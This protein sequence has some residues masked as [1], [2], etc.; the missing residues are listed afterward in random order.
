MLILRRSF[1]AAVRVKRSEF[2][3]ELAMLE[4]QKQN[5]PLREIEKRKLKV[6]REKRLIE[7]A[8]ARFTKVMNGLHAL[9]ARRS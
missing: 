3:R 5:L 7:R 9:D 2:A 4:A 8:E 6:A 1:D